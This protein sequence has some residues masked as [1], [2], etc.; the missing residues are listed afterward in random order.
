MDRMRQLAVFLAV[1][2]VASACLT[3][4]DGKSAGGRLR[5]VAA[6]NF[7]G[8]L[9]SQV[10]GSDVEVTSLISNPSADP[11]EYQPSRTAQLRV[12]TADVV[13]LNGADYDPFMTRLLDSSPSSHRR[14][15]D[16]AKLVGD[17]G[18]DAN[19]HLW[20]DLPALP[21]VL[22]A[23]SDAFTAAD[24]DHAR[25][26][27]NGLHATLN[28]LAPL[29]HAVTSIA[30]H[31]RGVPVAYT[32][33]VPGD[34]L[35]AA[36]LTVVTPPGFARSIEA[37]TEPSFADIAAMRDVITQHRAKVLLYNSQATSPVTQQLQSL[38]RVNGVPVVP[39]TETMPVDH[40]YESWQLSQV[41]ALARALGEATR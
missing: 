22:T 34:L 1:I 13:I 18:S 7:W 26:Y 39:I 32:E 15:I 4:C 33:R 23:M 40:T 8:D 30:T 2:V 17:T 14:V 3:A 35:D 38:A 16:V 6:E 24:F 27:K 31:Y 41:H 11:H 36:A 37:G 28:R 9:A 5:V 29:D 25:D 20:Y 12:A 10:G 19:P 21:Q